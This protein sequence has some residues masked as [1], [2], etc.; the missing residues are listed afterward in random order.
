MIAV[1][2]RTVVLPTH[3]NNSLL[4]AAA[5]H[6]REDVLDLLIRHGANPSDNNMPQVLTTAALPLLS[7]PANDTSCTFRCPTCVP[8]Q[9][10]TSCALRGGRLSLR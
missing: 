1:I 7:F 2:A 3:A 10:M 6:G 4:Q 9:K 8:A 5:V